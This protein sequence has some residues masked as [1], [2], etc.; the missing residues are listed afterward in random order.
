MKNILFRFIIFGVLIIGCF[1]C[2]GNIP[3]TEELDTDITELAKQIELA[4]KDAGKYESGLIK[5]LSDLRKEI[6]NNTKVMLEQKKSG[7]KR[8]I[9]LNYTIDGKKY[10]PPPNKAELLKEIEDELTEQDQKKKK[11]QN[12]SDKYIGGLIKGMI[13][14]QLATVKN[15]IAMLEQKHLALKHDMP[16]YAFSQPSGDAKEKEEFKPT[17]GKDIDKL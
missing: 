1:S 17:P 16:L 9:S 3:S 15:T 4:Q 11:M 6:L 7:I 5:V 14:I 2:S 13:E 12:E 8:F 10:K